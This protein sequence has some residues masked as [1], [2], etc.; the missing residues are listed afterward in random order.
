MTVEIGDLDYRILKELINNPEKIS[1]MEASL[2][3]ETCIHIISGNRTTSEMMEVYNRTKTRQ[4][5]DMDELKI[6]RYL[7]KD[8]NINNN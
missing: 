4:G 3:I 2:I 1:E 6:L 8:H 7:T 5:R